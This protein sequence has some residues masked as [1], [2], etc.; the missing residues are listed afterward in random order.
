MSDGYEFDGLTVVKPEVVSVD[1]RDGGVQTIT[2]VGTAPEWQKNPSRGE[3]FSAKKG[4]TISVYARFRADINLTFPAA[5]KVRAQFNGN[6]IGKMQCN[7][8][9]I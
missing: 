3:L 2:G 7:A 9:K 5:V 8:N 6:S 1:F 4:S